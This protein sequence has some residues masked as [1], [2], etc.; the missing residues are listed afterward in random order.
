MPIA[1]RVVERRLAEP[2]IQQDAEIRAPAGRL[3]RG[4]QAQLLEVG[5]VLV[6]DAGGVRHRLELG[7]VIERHGQDL[8]PF[9][10]A[11]GR[12]VDLLEPGILAQRVLARAVLE[13]ILQLGPARHGR[14]AAVARHGKRAAGIGVLAAGL[15]RLVAQIAA[16]KA[17]HEGIA[18]AQHVEHLDR[19][20]RPLDA[21]LDVVR[22]FSV[23]HGAAHRPA[24]DH[25]QRAPVRA[26]GSGGRPRA[27]RSSRRR[28]GSP[29]RCRRRRRSP[30]RWSAGGRSPRG[31][32]RS[33][34]RPG[35]GRSAPT[36]PAGSRCRRRPC[37]RAF[38]PGASPS[39]SWHRGSAWRNACPTPGPPW[40]MR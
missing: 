27:C 18:R 35:H 20:A 32:R 21:L 24:L 1:A 25:D 28:C 19:K 30:A 7:A 40:P 23:E 26:R 33:A 6:A 11:V 36:A 4:L 9:A 37:R 34:P 29:P 16:Q 13:E 8:G 22:D 2:A 5:D 15:D 17:A 10:R 38:S 14:R 12:P 3:A 31:S 39:C